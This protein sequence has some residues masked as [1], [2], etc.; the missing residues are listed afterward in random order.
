MTAADLRSRSRNSAY[1]GE[2]LHGRVTATFLRG[3]LTWRDGGDDRE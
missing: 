1:L 2:T 3:R